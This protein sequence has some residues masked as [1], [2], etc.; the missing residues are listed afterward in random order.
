MRSVS[1]ILKRASK[2][3]LPE[4]FRT[5]TA[6]PVSVLLLKSGFSDKTGSQKMT[7]TE[8]G[9]SQFGARLRTFTL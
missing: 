2:E 6:S 9:S 5:H 7:F 8:C 4:G 3:L 1:G